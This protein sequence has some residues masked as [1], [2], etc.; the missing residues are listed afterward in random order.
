MYMCALV[1]YVVLRKRFRSSGLLNASVSLSTLAITPATW[2]EAIEVPERVA[3]P[4]SGVVEI[5]S[6]P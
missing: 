2:G 6:D 3:M 5:I 1:A 4:P